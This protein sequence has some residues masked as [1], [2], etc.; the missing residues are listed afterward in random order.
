MHAGI[1]PYKYKT[2]HV[3]VVDGATGEP[4]SEAKVETIYHETHYFHQPK[5]SSATT[6]KNGA[7]SVQ[8]AEGTSDWAVHV[9]CRDYYLQ[10]EWSSSIPTEETV[11]LFRYPKITVTVPNNYVGPLKIELP[12][13]HDL[14]QEDIR[15]KEYQFREM[16]TDMLISIRLTTEKIILIY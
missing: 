6:D 4:V 1:F 2:I 8:V 9:K 15:R 12:L 3:T 5:S 10:S 11:R 13:M 7:A 14:R 16:G